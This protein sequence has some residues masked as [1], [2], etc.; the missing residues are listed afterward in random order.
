MSEPQKVRSSKERGDRNNHDQ[1][2]QLALID[3]KDGQKIVDALNSAKMVAVLSGKEVMYVF[4][5]RGEYQCFIHEF[6]AED[7]RR[8]S[9]AIN[10]RNTAMMK[11][12]NS[13]ADQIF[14]ITPKPNMHP[15]GVMVAAERGIIAYLDATGQLPV[16]DTD[17]M[18]WQNTDGKNNSEGG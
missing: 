7:G 9:F 15:M 14:E 1:D 8:K 17:F 11:N 16:D 13:A 5:F 2:I 3:K 6:D 12:L 18:D 10:E 4:A